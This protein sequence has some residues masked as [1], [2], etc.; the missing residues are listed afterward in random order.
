MTTVYVRRRDMQ[1]PTDTEPLIYWTL[2]TTKPAS[3]DRSNEK[4]Q[5]S[6]TTI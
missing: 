3:R 6:D 1:R 2:S 4:S 5:V